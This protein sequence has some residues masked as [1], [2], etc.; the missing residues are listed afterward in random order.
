MG[1]SPAKRF[2]YD[3]PMNTRHTIAQ[4]ALIALLL[5]VSAAMGVWN[6][7]VAKERKERNARVAAIYAVVTAPA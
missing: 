4:A 7:N 2:S 3:P 6:W 5:A 1:S